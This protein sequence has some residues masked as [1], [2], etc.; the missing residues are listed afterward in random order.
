MTT[1]KI[2]ALT[3]Q[4]FTVEKNL[5]ISGHEQWKSLFSKG[6]LL[7]VVYLLISS[8]IFAVGRDSASLWSY[9]LKKTYMNG[10]SSSLSRSGLQREG[11]AQ[12]NSLCGEVLDFPLIFI[13]HIKVT[14][15]DGVG[16]GG[17]SQ[18]RGQKVNRRN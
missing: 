18:G 16:D 6:Q 3:R 8:L 9:S 5:Y 10:I 17:G 15:W 14:N 13:C 11:G 4:T 2:I 7:G 12:D 1:G